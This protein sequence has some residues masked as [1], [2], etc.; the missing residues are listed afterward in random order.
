MDYSTEFVTMCEA[1]AEL[2]DMVEHREITQK[3]FFA[4]KDDIGGDDM[5][6][7]PRQDQIQELIISIREGGDKEDG[8]LDDDGD[9]GRHAVGNLLED[10]HGIYVK[11]PFAFTLEQACLCLLMEEISFKKWN[12]VSKKWEVV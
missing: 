4:K 8:E 7:L 10:I 11:N 5:I 3:D 6:W 2:Q 12:V 9:N 1:A